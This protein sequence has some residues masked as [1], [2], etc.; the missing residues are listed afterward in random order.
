MGNFEKLGVLVII[1]LVAVL[2][3]IVIFGG[4]PQEGLYTNEVPAQLSAAG[5]AGGTAAP[6]AEPPAAEREGEEPA[7]EDLPWPRQGGS[8]EEDAGRRGEEAAPEEGG[9][10]EE[11]APPP[12]PEF[13]EH[14]VKPHESYWK[15]SRLY[16]G[17][18]RYVKLLEKANPAVDPDAIP[19]GTKLRIPHPDKVLHR[20]AAAAEEP[21][22]SPASPPLRGNTYTVQK[23]DTLT[24]IARKTMGPGASWK[25]LY[26]ANRDRIGPN[27]NDLPAGLTLTIPQD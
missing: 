26:A 2:F 9:P 11:A 25:K 16:Y 4:A 18:V 24:S 15:I 10:E 23:G 3:V 7:G 27:P 12:A 20:G 17:S 19:V 14:V 8:A 22:T 13:L 5:Q 21:G 6:A 1:I